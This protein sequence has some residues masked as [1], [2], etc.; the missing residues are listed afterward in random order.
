MWQMLIL[1]LIIRLTAL[2]IHSFPNTASW[3][4]YWYLLA[5]KEIQT[6]QL[7]VIFPLSGMSRLEWP[8]GQRRI[9]NGYSESN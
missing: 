4:K 6:Q 1:A 3:M 2:I 8:S 5:K 7:D 9:H